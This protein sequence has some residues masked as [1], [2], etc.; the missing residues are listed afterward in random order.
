MHSNM[1][2]V[3]LESFCVLRNP[4]D[5]LAGCGSLTQKSFL[6]D[7]R[8]SNRLKNLILSV[9]S[10]LVQAG[11]SHASVRVTIQRDIRA[12]GNENSA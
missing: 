5:A 11:M 10:K 12:H 4:R 7:A 8:V 2:C 6:L 9:L 1:S 3:A